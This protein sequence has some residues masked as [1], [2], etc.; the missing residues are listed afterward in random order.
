MNMKR[1]LAGSGCSALMMATLVLGLTFP[2]MALEDANEQSQHVA[3]LI[4]RINDTMGLRASTVRSVAYPDGTPPAFSF[5]VE[6]DGEVQT[7]TLQR[8]SLLSHKYQLL[9]DHGTG[10]L[11]EVESNAPA[12]YK[13]TLASGQ[14]LAAITLTSK[15]MR[16]FVDAGDGYW[17]VQPLA[18]VEPTADK[19]S[20]FLYRAEDVIDGDVKCGVE[21]YESFRDTLQTSDFPVGP[22][23]AGGGSAVQIAEVAFDAD[24]ENFSF[25]GSV[26]AVEEDIIDIMNAVEAQYDVQIGIRY[27]ITAIVVRD[28]ITDPYFTTDSANALLDNFRSVW[29]T[30]PESNI[31]R[32]VAHLRT[33]QLPTGGPGPT[34][35]GLA[36][37]GTVCNESLA[38]A[39]TNTRS[40]SNQ[41]ARIDV[42]A[43]ELGHN[44]DS[45]HCDDTPGPGLPFAGCCG[46]PFYTM[47]S[48]SIGGFGVR[49]EFCPPV[50]DIIE[51]FKNSRFCL[52]N[53]PPDAVLPVFDDFTSTQ[54]NEDL[55]VGD[56]VT[57]D[58]NGLAE[59]SPPRSLRINGAD[60]LTSGIFDTSTVCGV[61][62]EYWWQRTG[63]LGLAGSPEPGEDLVIEYRNA[64][65][66]W[67]IAPGGQ[68]PG[69][70]PDNAPYMFESLVLPEDAQHPA[71]QIRLRLLGTP[72]FSDNFFV[73]DISIFAAATPIGI[74]EQPLDD[75]ACPGGSGSFTV[76]PDGEPPIEFQWRKNGVDIPGET[77]DTLVLE[78]LDEDDF[79]EYT[80][81]VSNVCSSIETIV[82]ELIETETPTVLT[83]PVGATLPLGGNYFEFIS[84]TASPEFQWFKDNVALEGQTSFFLQ[85]DNVGCEDAGNYRCELTNDCGT[86]STNEVELVVDDESCLNDITPP[87][88]LHQ[89][90][91]TGQ[92]RPYTGYIDPRGES[93]DGGAI[94]L[95]VSEVFMLFSE[96]VRNIENGGGLTIDSFV[97]TETGGGT[98]PSVIAVDDSAMPVV[99]VT[100]DRPITPQ[101]WTTIRAIVEDASGN[102]IENG[103]DLGDVD[104]LD[105]I[106]IGY[107]PCDVDQS[108]AVSP[109]DLFL[110]RQYV[111]GV[112]TPDIGIVNDFIDTDRSNSISPLDL[113]LYR[114]LIAG[115]GPATQ[116]WGNATMNNDR[117]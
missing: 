107:L 87:R 70:G 53:A 60:L 63:G 18:D 15:G 10:E 11:V 104:E 68:H 17:Y 115:T 3:S 57:V 6:L 8:R 100:F 24:F 88:I 71:F 80:C 2:A 41:A 92:T 52:E 26:E 47:C 32:D 99:Q 98:P 55:W 82:A 103:G 23:A 76:I 69:A 90:G 117:P 56:G 58:T 42:V 93:S 101:E 28:A 111:N 4:D 79:A 96:G 13:G 91:Q 64:E 25:L 108:G 39:L 1:S 20:I 27:E 12:T 105:R 74:T 75:F 5:D 35:Q 19:S 86:I 50:V 59:P 61:T 67:V 65:G 116:A 106:D 73:D 48:V 112:T 30:P 43:H 83:Q 81:L 110:F 89:L 113:F 84:A 94:D 51:A 36:I 9:V 44:W 40:T 37:T 38:Y 33:S 31:D 14:G 54:I 45:P 46:N 109:I 95:G 102:A 21:G 97:V 62:I 85:V 78:S 66:D 29:N 34:V 72:N 77:S 49:N 114:Q 7:V 16:G 22:S